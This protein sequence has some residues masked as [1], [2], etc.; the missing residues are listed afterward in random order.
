MKNN[1]LENR[2]RKQKEE[3]ELH[4]VN[5]Y[6]DPAFPVGTYEVTREGILPEGRGYK[7]LHW[8][9]ELQ[10]TYVVK[11]E[12][13]IRI[14]GKDYIV[15]EGEVVFINRNLLHITTDLTKDGRYISLNFPDKLLGFFSGSR[16]EQDYVFPYTRGYMLPAMVLNK[17]SGWQKQILVEIKD[18]IDLLG[19]KEIKCREYQIAV[20]LTGMWQ[21]FIEH[22]QDEAVRPTRSYIRKQERIQQML[23]YIYEHYMEEIHLKDIAEAASVSVG[24]CCRC[25]QNMVRTTP[26]Q[27]LMEYRIE[28]S[29][30]LLMGTEMSVTEVAYAAGFSDSSYFIQC[31]R[32]YEGITPGE[33]GKC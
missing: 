32:K 29:K 25:F 11:G 10:F 6:T 21:M 3:K 33:Y 23:T 30:E 14:D 31:F 24:E 2:E 22:M 8:H 17:E 4:E 26:N 16:M 13:Q 5:R 18:I 28:K 9:E 15:K 20:K 7:D 1:T 12:L 19:Q 27:Y